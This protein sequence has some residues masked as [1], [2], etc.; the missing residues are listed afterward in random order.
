VSNDGLSN[1]KKAPIQ[2]IA[3]LTHVLLHHYKNMLG[4]QDEVTTS[5][6]DILTTIVHYHESIISS[7]P[8]NVYW[9]D[10]Q[11]VALGCNQNVLDMFGFKTIDQ[12]RGLSFEGMGTAAGWSSETTAVFKKDTLEVLK[13]GQPR[14]NIE[15]PPIAD[16]HGKKIHFLTSRV[17][18]FD[19]H[20]LVVGVVSISIDITQ[21]KKKEQ[22][23][24]E[25]KQQAEAAN[26]AKTRFLEEMRHDMRTPLS[27][28]VGIAELL[29]T[30][31]NQDKAQE[32]TKWLLASSQEL[33]EFLNNVLDSVN[34]SSG[35]IP[36]SIQRFKLY[37]TIERVVK[38]HQAKAFEKRLDLNFYV[39]PNIPTFLMGDPVR[40]YRIVL[41]LLSNALKFTEKGS[42]D[43]RVLLSEK[44][45]CNMVIGFEIQDTGP[46][47]PKDRQLDLFT[48]F[49]RLTPSYKGLYQGSGL[50]LS[51]AKTF[52]ED[53]QGTLHVESD[54]K[55]GSQF[56]CLFPLK[57]APLHNI[58]TLDA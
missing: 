52:A 36:V 3:D 39:D 20:G 33:M 32:Y 57:E 2:T 19:D 22:A 55:T 6:Q 28:I 14:L 58:P 53:L 24:V 34:S 51:I 7:M 45:D 46:G 54:G 10:K 41:E 37:E 44:T 8:G 43:V 5:V 11:G 42:V 29:N 50:G 25:A 27:G 31:Q 1:G 48:R 18:L 13:K 26:N 4:P 12:F 15:E 40:I 56:I 30:E 9:L 23:L 17:P 49:N 47:I 16:I 35:H 21:R 38:L